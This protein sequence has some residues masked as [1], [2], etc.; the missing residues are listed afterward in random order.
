MMIRF[1]TFW[2]LLFCLTGVVPS[3][4][5]AEMI[6]D[7]NLSEEK[8]IR[9][10]VLAK[11][12]QERALEKWQPTA[13][14]LN[15]NIPQF[16]FEI[17]PLDFSDVRKAVAEEKIEFLITN[18]GYYVELETE[19]G[20]SR[21]ATLKNQLNSTEK[22]VFGGVIFTRADR[23]D[24][25]K[26]SDLVNRTF[27]AVDR[28]SLGGWQMA[29]REL[30]AQG[31]RPLHDLN[32]S[33]LGT[34]DAVVYGVLE[35]KGDAGTVRTDTL[36]RM[37]GEGVLD[38]SLLKIIN[39]RAD[40]EDFPFLLSTR[41][42]PEWPF[43][44]MKQTSDQLAERVLIALLDLGADSQ[45]A[46]AAQISGWTVPLDYQPIHELMQ[47]LYIGP[48][49]R[50]MGKIT[51]QDSI[52]EHWRVILTFVAVFSLL[53][54]IILIVLR[55]NRKLAV[56]HSSLSSQ[57]KTNL[58]TNKALKNSERNYREIFDNTN[59]A[60]FVHDRSFSTI[61]DVN[62]ATCDMYGYTKDEIKDLSIKAV[63]SNEPPYTKIEAVNWLKKNRAEGPQAF[64]WRARK[65]NGELFW[66]EVNLKEAKIGGQTRLL[67][68]VRNINQ[69]K[70]IE[71]Q[72]EQYRHHL[73]KLIEDRTEAL[74]KSNLKLQKKENSLAEAQRI[75]H[76]GSWDW[77]VAKN[78]LWWSDEVY[79]IFGL[80]PDKFDATYEAFLASVHPDD[81]TRVKKAVKNALMRGMPYS[82]Q[83]RII[84][85]DNTRRIIHERGEIY[86]DS[87]GKPERMI[88]TVQNITETKQAEEEKKRLESQLMQAQKMEAIGTLA[89]G[90]AHDFNN[91]LTTIMGFSEIARML[92]AAQNDE[93]QDHLSHIHKAGKRARDLVAQIL[94]FSRKNHITT[95]PVQLSSIVKEALKML[96]ATL[97]TT[98]EFRQNIPAVSGQIMADP[99]QI[100]HI[101]MN[102]CTNAAH[103]MHNGVGTLSISLT[104]KKLAHEIPGLLP[105]LYLKLSISDTGDGIPRKI[106]DRIF[107]PFFTTKDKGIG[108]GMGLSVVHG[109]VK[110]YGGDITFT[111]EEGIGTTFDLY[112]PALLAVED[113]GKK[114]TSVLPRGRGE[115]I[116]FVDDEQQVLNIGRKILDFLGYKVVCLTSSE[117]ALELFRV[118]PD[119]FDLVLTDQTMPKMT[120]TD[121]AKKMLQIR[122]DIPII[123]C[124]GYSASLTEDT[125]KKIGMKG[126]IL[127]PFV[128]HNL[129]IEIKKVL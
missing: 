94:T 13:L 123:L 121:L 71:E 33:F 103:A 84:L 76:L 89:G 120:G 115:R 129:A 54:L 112:F 125:I 49:C 118:Q 122:P 111:S 48:Y 17:V 116:L 43:T 68:V 124:T 50:A 20:I 59:D 28:E 90:I 5:A 82:I 88:G 32:I 42:Y 53:L 3:L 6:H 80:D 62:Q 23:N 61:L 9:I 41:L 91:S 99:T 60:I 24:I 126:L 35:G 37:A 16:S 78:E 114:M 7:E 119:N 104:E 10:G 113:P 27:Y 8:T 66:V 73:E 117:K 70:A 93:L 15:K 101:I 30:H 110:S 85:P 69:R 38:L 34:H 58:R 63:S 29:W 1:C 127:K 77:Q 25:N 86:L 102:L 108:T 44:K 21:I 2:L 107:E 79:H 40:S 36:E 74:K 98:I 57:L 14:Y 31:I 128:V 64:E 18:S 22:N 47:E 65:K 95:H 81:R 52:K 26:I 45:A 83:H 87:H 56:V 4:S 46:Q 12:G 92:P 51:L 106:R 39:S 55:F 105:G 96:R 97:P 75:A 19:F 11:R 67:A 100:H 109:I 72:L